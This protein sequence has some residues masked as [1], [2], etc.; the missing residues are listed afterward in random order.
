[1]NKTKKAYT[2]YLNDL[3]A[4]IYSAEEAYEQFCYFKNGKIAR[5]VIYS[6]H[7][8]HILGVLLRKNDPIRF[9]LG[10]NEWIKV[11]ATG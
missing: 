10:F 1:M 7:A 5:S 9:N 8:N 6:A 3:F 11:G 2:D 4:D